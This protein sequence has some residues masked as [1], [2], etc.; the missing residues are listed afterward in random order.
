VSPTNSFSKSGYAIDLVVRQRL[1]LSRGQLRICFE[2]AF[3]LEGLRPRP[4]GLLHFGRRPRFAGPLGED[5]SGLTRQRVHGEVAGPFAVKILPICVG[6][7]GRSAP[8]NR[9]SA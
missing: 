7:A 9:R 5:F 6:L 2:L 3:S 4:D 1:L 8:L